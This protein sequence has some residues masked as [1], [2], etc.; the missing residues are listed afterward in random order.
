MEAK[1]KLGISACILGNPVRYNGGHARDSF[2]IET[3]APHVD[4][5]SVCPEVECG[6][7]IPR[8]AIR[9]VGDLDRPRLLSSKTGEDFTARMQQWAIHR[10]D[11]LASEDLCGFIFK[12]GSP[13]CGLHRVRVYREDGRPPLTTGTGIFARAFTEQFPLIPVEEEGRLHDPVLREH[14]IERIFVMRRWRELMNEPPSR[15]R[16]VD[17]HTR[18]KLLL[19]AHSPECYRK[20]GK[21]VADLGNLQIEEAYNRYLDLLAT[22]LALK[23]TVRKQVNVLLHML[24]YFK[25]QLSGDEKQEMLEVIEAYRLER[26]PLIVPITLFK[27][28]IR[29]YGQDYL[30]AQH[31]I[32]PHPR[33]LK[34]R[35]HC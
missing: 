16:L 11:G 18:H 20:M 14:F 33:E 21:L 12:K 32:D 25:K 28:Y 35:N 2:V 5:I 24:G 26:L 6:M 8:E 34:L 10:L 29:K 22:T 4:F 1:I 27:H 19:L 17:F 15:R 7:S 9:L 23:S 3:F 30:A 31:Y 13:S